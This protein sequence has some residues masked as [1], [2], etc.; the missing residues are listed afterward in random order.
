MVPSQSWIQKNLKAASKAINPKEVKKITVPI[1]IL[2]AKQDVVIKNKLLNEF[3]ELLPKNCEL[4]VFP[5]KHELF[6][7]KDIVR[8]QVIHRSLEFFKRP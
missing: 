8:D 2:K 6:I 7:E 4:D 1:L 3:C 5:G